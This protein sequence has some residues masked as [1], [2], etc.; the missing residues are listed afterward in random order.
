MTTESHRIPTHRL[1]VRL[2]RF[3][4]PGAVTIPGTTQAPNLAPLNR[5][6][7]DITRCVECG[8]LGWT[9]GCLEGAR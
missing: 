3:H 2:R 1:E 9:C 7:W 5:D 8:K 6:E 4:V